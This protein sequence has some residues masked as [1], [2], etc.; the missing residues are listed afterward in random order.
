MMIVIGLFART[1]G[2]CASVLA[3]IESSF[4]MHFKLNVPVAGLPMLFDAFCVGRG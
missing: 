2:T 1:S 4:V 3:R